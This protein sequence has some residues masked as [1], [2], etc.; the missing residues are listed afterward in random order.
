VQEGDENQFTNS[1]SFLG[2]CHGP[3]S[4]TPHFYML[5]FWMRLKGLTTTLSIKLAQDDL[6]IVKDLEI[7][8]DDKEYIKNLVEKR[9]WGPSVLIV[10]E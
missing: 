2:R 9:N 5:P 3:R 8:T 4:P 6:H 1:R 10:D 7:P